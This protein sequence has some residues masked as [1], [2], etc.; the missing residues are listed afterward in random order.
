MEILKSYLLLLSYLFPNSSEYEDEFVQ[1]LSHLY[2]NHSS[3]SWDHFANVLIS[4]E[5]AMPY[6][7]RHKQESMITTAES[8]D[9]T[10]YSIQVAENPKFDWSTSFA[11]EWIREFNYFFQEIDLQ[12]L[13]L[14]MTNGSSALILSPTQEVD[15]ILSTAHQLLLPPI[16]YFQPY[17]NHSSSHAF[18]H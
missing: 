5:L 13:E 14:P 6:T 10:S 17:S 7:L 8:I 1:R 15:S 11:T 9:S 18:I 12:I 16:Y 3:S 2:P 4:M